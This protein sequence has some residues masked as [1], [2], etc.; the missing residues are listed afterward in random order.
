[1]NH[2]Y[3]ALMIHEART[4]DLRTE[5]RQHNLVRQVVRAKRVLAQFGADS[6][7]RALPGRAE[8]AYSTAVGGDRK[9]A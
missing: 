8:A 9:A 4:A 7:V 1:M 5:A 6:T 3:M 2:D